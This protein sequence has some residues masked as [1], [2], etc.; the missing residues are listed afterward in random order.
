MS[1]ALSNNKSS[2]RGPR[3]RCL[4][5]RLFSKASNARPIEAHAST[6]SGGAS[7]RAIDVRP[8]LSLLVSPSVVVRRARWRSRIVQPVRMPSNAAL[9]T[10]Y[11]VACRRDS[12][13]T[14]AVKT[15]APRALRQ[16]A[17]CNTLATQTS[18]AQIG[19]QRC[20]GSLRGHPG[21]SG[22]IQRQRLWVE[23]TASTRAALPDPEGSKKQHRA[24]CRGSLARR[25]Q[26]QHL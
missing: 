24:V 2:T 8:L 9:V 10:G 16:L 19:L 21:A 1:N 17:C 12:Y 13:A 11:A 5:P 6:A 4:R 3:L 26:K 20:Y 22:V 18:V 14:S 7:C 15:P 23:H 25:R